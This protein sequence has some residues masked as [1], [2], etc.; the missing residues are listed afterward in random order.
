MCE[1]HITCRESFPAFSNCGSILKAEVTFGAMQSQ[2]VPHGYDILETTFILNHTYK[3]RTHNKVTAESIPDYVFSLYGTYVMVILLL[4]ML[5]NGVT[6]FVF[7][8]TRRLWK[9]HNY[10]IVGL[11]FSDLGMCLF[12]NWLIVAS[13]FNRRWIFQR[14]GR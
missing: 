4:G 10:F 5:Q 14:V 12:G 13:A 9:V 7:L 11:A 3:N 6:L 1:G 2:Q 8:R